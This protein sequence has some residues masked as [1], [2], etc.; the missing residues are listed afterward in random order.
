[1]V[2]VRVISTARTGTVD[3]L[4][5]VREYEVLSAIGHGVARVGVSRL[6]ERNFSVRQPPAPVA[7]HE[8]QQF[9]GLDE[10]SV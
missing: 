9:S 10:R 7:I 3:L 1:M 6:L 5:W 8:V 4:L 2:R